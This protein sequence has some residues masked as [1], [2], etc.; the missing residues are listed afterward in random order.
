MWFKMTFFEWASRVPLI[1]HAPGRIAPA[2]CA[3]NVSLVDLLPTLLELSGARD[4][5]SA[6][7]DGRSLVPLLD[8]RGTEW[9]DTVLGEYFAE[10]S[11]APIFM[12]RQR[13]YKYISCRADP[14]QLFDIDTDPAE[15]SNLASS[16]EHAVPERRLAEIV[17][18]TWDSDQLFGDIVASQQ[19]RRL[20][21]Q[22]L[23][24]G[25][26]T[27]WDYEPPHA[28]ARAYIRNIEGLYEREARAFLPPRGRTDGDR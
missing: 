26:R 14:P 6:E 2:R 15:L 7:L 5:D 10:G 23:M 8:G 24:T 17:D 28:E 22:A 12:V 9:P 13:S 27:L 19:R 3:R 25:H 11:V 4:P 20:V 16:A 21:F 18:V 1:F